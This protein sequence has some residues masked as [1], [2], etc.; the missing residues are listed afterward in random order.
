MSS[1]TSWSASSTESAPPPYPNR[2]RFN[3][4]TK[5]AKNPAVAEQLTR[6]GKADSGQPGSDSNPHSNTKTQKARQTADISR[7]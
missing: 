7:L 3:P 2:I 6:I 4:D 5:N 1:S